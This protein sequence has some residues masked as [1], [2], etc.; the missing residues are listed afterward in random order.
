MQVSFEPHASIDVDAEIQ[1]S[2]DSFFDQRIEIAQ[3]L[4]GQYGALWQAA[5]QASEG[6]KKLRPAL[7]VSVYREFAGNQI[8]HAVSAATAFE[9]LHTAFLMHDD[10]IDQDTVRRGRLNIVGSFAEVAADR[11]AS[12]ADA[13]LWGQ[14][15]AILA[16]DLLIQAAQSTLARLPIC[17]NQ[18]LALLDLFDHC[19]FVTAAGELADVAF[20]TGAESPDLTDVL[21]MAEQKTASYSFEGPLQAGAILADAGPDALKALGEFGRLVGTAFQ[22]RDDILGVFGDEQV[23]GKSVVSD[24][25]AGKITALVA[26]ALRSNHADDLKQLLARAEGVDADGD[27]VR[28]ILEQCG[29]R[30]FVE[31]LIA[32]HVHRAIELLETPALPASLQ[33]KLRDVARRATERLR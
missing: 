9:L 28:G 21:A 20:A 16:G 4:G 6:G 23:T 31:G 7:V 30:S 27:V 13:L 32:D 15:S 19:V 29:A 24:L 2:I 18:R 3:G 10:V 1:R 33:I 8:T 12:N 26:Y 22:L 5:R 11:G 14:A 25:R 17:E